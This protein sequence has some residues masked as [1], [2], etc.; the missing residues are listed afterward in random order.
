VS[1]RWRDAM[2]LLFSTGERAEQARKRLAMSYY[3]T[4]HELAQQA[5]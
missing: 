2:D 5:V 1:F 3:R 4:Q